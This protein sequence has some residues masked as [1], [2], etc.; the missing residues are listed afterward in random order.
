M[1]S[2][3]ITRQGFLM[4]LVSGGAT[5][6]LGCGDDAGS[7][8]ASGATATTG[9]GPSGTTGSAQTTSIASGTAVATSATQAVGTTG[10]GMNACAAM[11]VATISNNH[12]HSLVVPLADIDAGVDVTYDTSGT[13]MHCHQVTVT[14]ADFQTLKAGGVVI[15]AACNG[16]TDHEYVLSCAPG[17]P[18][19]GDPDCSQDPMLGAC[20]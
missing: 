5:V 13:A 17:A 4:G 14:A 18:L 9:A 7:G 16:Q 1:A 19:G 3:Q 8:G 11:I 15:K 20:P 2:R 10:T 12:N 6:A